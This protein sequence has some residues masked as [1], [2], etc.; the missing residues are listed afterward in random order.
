MPVLVCAIALERPRER[1]NS[2]RREV[3]RSNIFM[4][5]ASFS[6]IGDKNRS[7]RKSR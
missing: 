3:L 4:E 2:R 7:H 6:E 5:I 1:I